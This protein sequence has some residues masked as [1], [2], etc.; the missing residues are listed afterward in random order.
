[1]EPAYAPAYIYPVEGLLPGDETLPFIANIQ[2]FDP[3]GDI[4]IGWNFDNEP[5]HDLP[6]FWIVYVRG[7]FQD[8]TRNA[9]GDPDS[10]SL[11]T[12]GVAHLPGVTVGPIMGCNIYYEAFVEAGPGFFV[13]EDVVVHEVGH[14]FGC[15]HPHGGI[16]GSGTTYDPVA[17]FLPVSLDV[18]RN[19]LAP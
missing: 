4:T 13:E 1:M 6:R 9:D 3:G 17:G 11:L 18:I 16:M 7:A 12:F 19:S 8:D 2:T 5:N 10:E 14:V 15:V